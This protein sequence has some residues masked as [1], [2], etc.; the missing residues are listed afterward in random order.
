MIPSPFEASVVPGAGRGKT[1]GTPTINLDPALLAHIGREGIYACWA[2]LDGARHPAVM[3]A[4]ARPVFRDTASIELY[5][6]DGAPE[7][8]PERIRVESV[9]Y[10]R[11]IRDFPSIDDLTAQIRDDIRAARATLGVDAPPPQEARS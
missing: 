9:A 6:L 2:T 10:L 3:H 11:E 4:G 5:L 7:T 8:V 1:L